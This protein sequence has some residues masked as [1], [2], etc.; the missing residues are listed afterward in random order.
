MSRLFISHASVDNV[1]AVAIRDWLKA[2]GWDEVFLDIDPARGISAGE[3]WERA[4]NEA[5][6]RCE[7]IVFIISAAWLNSPWC[8][9]EFHLARRLNKRLFGVLV[10]PIELASLPDQLTGAWQVVDLVSGQ[11]GMT[12]RVILPHTHD[13]AHVTFSREGLDRLR[14][15]LTKAGLDPRFFAWPPAAD[16]DRSPYPGLKPLEAEDAGIFFGREAPIVDTLD[17]LRGLRELAPPRIMVIL[18]A[19]GSG[20]SSFLRAG[21]LPRL[22]R[23]DRNFLPLPVIRPDRAAISGDAGLV[24]AIESA[25]TA[26]GITKR[27]ADLKRS[28]AEGAVG[29]KALLQELVNISFKRTLADSPA[30]LPPSVIIAVDQAEELFAEDGAT[31]GATLLTLLRELVRD[32]TP[33]IIVLFTIRSDSYDRLETAKPLEGVKQHAIPLLPMP[34]GAYQTVIEAPAAR[35]SETPRKLTIHPQL[36][37]RLLHDIEK[38]GASDALPLLAFTLEQLYL[39]YGRGSGE[40]RLAD[41]EN[42][43]GIGGAIS[44]AVERAFIA[45]D[46]DHRIPR[47]RDAR[48]LLLRRG[49]IPWL[50]GI[51]PETGSPRRR[52]ARRADVPPESLPLID[53]LVEQRLLTTDRVALGEGEHRHYEIT[54]EP[55]HEALLRQWGLLAGWLSE[56]I[57]ALSILETVKAAA[58]DYAANDEAAD[59]LNHAGGRLE[60]AERV[61][62]ERPDLALELSANARTYLRRCRERENARRNA[63]LRRA[64]QIATGALISAVVAI[65]LFVY[66]QIEANQANQNLALAD[67]TLE[68]ATNIIND[69]DNP[70][71]ANVTNELDDIQNITVQAKKFASFDPLGVAN[72]ELVAAQ[73]ERNTTASPIAVLNAAIQVLTNVRQQNPNSIEIEFDYDRAIL[74]RARNEE[75]AQQLNLASSDFAASIKD[76]ESLLNAQMT[77]DTRRSFLVNLGHADED[78]NDLLLQQTTAQ[79]PTS[80]APAVAAI[81]AAQK[82]FSDYKSEYPTDPTG[83]AELAWADLKSGDIARREGNYQDALSIFTSAYNAMSAIPRA[84]LN[85]NPIWPRDLAIVDLNLG[86]IQLRLGNFAGASTSFQNADQII[87]SLPVTIEVESD[88][89]FA[90]DLIGFS[91]YLCAEQSGNPQCQADATNALA[92]AVSIRADVH[93]R[94][95]RR[96]QWAQ[97]VEHTNATLAALN[98]LKAMNAADDTSAIHDFAQAASITKPLAEGPELEN[99]LEIFRLADFYVHEGEAEAQA[100]QNDAAK[101]SFSA[102][103]AS[104]QSLPKDSGGTVPLNKLT[105][106]LTTRLQQDLS[107]L[108]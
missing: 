68:S 105:T 17:T 104:L 7:A 65:G 57:T 29:V 44:A 99:D 15:G 1:S 73:T 74:A 46:K 26:H 21:L 76:M 62:A 19:S 5:A 107:K 42:F 56:D 27:R 77:P 55:A 32:D 100:K 40:L 79:D 39:D 51:D 13:E 64:W 4:L 31:E 90:M 34:R 35:L 84:S 2:N 93:A 83:P 91:N 98:G 63:A 37:Q 66:A 82:V 92:T 61:L 71:S 28:V 43:N 88:H 69:F 48:L 33:A 78:F 45:A 81:T 47:D 101:Q 59:W 103:Q 75:D 3:R 80:L 25:F 50:A 9:K 53:L 54:I 96:V 86:D 97:D 60:D 95:P 102:A 10:E 6:S 20:K 106:P 22:T 8:L 30:A 11:D 16:P 67:A 85:E 24:A 70:D 89:G 94:A 41:Y 18:G 52:V 14:R 36:T 12:M 72:L 58:R 23:D 108:P 87:L 38:G 49:F